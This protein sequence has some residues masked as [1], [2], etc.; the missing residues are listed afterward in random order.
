M[1]EQF[2]IVMLHKPYTKGS[3]RKI[4]MRKLDHKENNPF[5]HYAIARQ[6]T[7]FRIPVE[8]NGVQPH[9]CK[10][11]WYKMTQCIRVGA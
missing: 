4:I 2:G 8:Y 5:S 6:Q 7:P 9:P 11:M 1:Y 3:N 10:A